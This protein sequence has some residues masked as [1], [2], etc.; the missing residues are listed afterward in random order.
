MS[1]YHIV[2]AWAP[3]HVTGLFTPELEAPD[4]RAR[5]STGAGLVLDLGVTAVASRERSDSLSLEVASDLGIPLPISTQAARTLLAVR[6]GR[7]T[8]LLRHD[9]PVGQGFG[10]SAAGALAT[11]LS[12]AG[13]IGLSR[14]RAVEAAH[15]AELRF[16][17]GLG[18]VAATLGGGLE[19]RTRAGLPPRGQVR[20]IPKRDRVLLAIG[21]PPIP[22]PSRLADR[23]LLQQLRVAGSS[24]LARLATEPT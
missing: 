22:T 10:M 21:G 7:F 1:G 19:I 23:K 20:R 11:G 15:R 24:G 2:E 6:K 4:P 18:G 9:L 8:V 13:L 5:G 12:I 3:G 17:G 16:G 14:S